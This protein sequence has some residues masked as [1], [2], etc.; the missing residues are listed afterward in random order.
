MHATDTI[1]GDKS[2]QPSNIK[3]PSS[4]LEFPDSLKL[5]KLNHK[6]KQYDAMRSIHLK[7]SNILFFNQLGSVE[8]KF[9]PNLFFNCNVFNNII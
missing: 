3:G 6:E 4:Q 1:F 9:G 8:Y 5:I 2:F 7:D